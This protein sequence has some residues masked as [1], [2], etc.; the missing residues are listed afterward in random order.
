MRKGAMAD[1][2]EWKKIS[3]LAD[4]YRQ[5]TGITPDR[6]FAGKPE[7]GVAKQPIPDQTSDKGA[8]SGNAPDEGANEERGCLGSFLPRHSDPPGHA[9]PLS[10]PI[11]DEAARAM[12][13]VLPHL[14][15]R[16][17]TTALTAALPHLEAAWRQRHD[18]P[19]MRDVGIE[20]A[21]RADERAKVR[22]RV[23]ALKQNDPGEFY[24]GYDEAI[25]DALAAI[26][27][28]EQDDS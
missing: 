17:I 22:E 7:T 16:E 8:G 10:E 1:P 3:D 4:E 15:H 14:T 6:G 23:E 27:E 5:T 11:P 2:A 24:V 26:D 12:A 9:M 13:A 18:S 28:G 20:A 21:I 25:G 19:H